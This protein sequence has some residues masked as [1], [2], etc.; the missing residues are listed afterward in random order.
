M[1]K[2]EGPLP[3]GGRY[4]AATAKRTSL[5]E[6]SS[7]STVSVGVAMPVIRQARPITSMPSAVAAKNVVA[8]A[9]VETASLVGLERVTNG[10]IRLFRRQEAIRSAGQNATAVVDN[11]SAPSASSEMATSATVMA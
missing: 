6:T 9:P 2:T 10:L 4:A 8:V 11:V 3:N 7:V 1:R 5:E